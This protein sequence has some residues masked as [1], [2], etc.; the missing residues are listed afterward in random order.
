MNYPPIKD[1][2]FSWKPYQKA[3]EKLENAR[4]SRREL[5]R[6]Q[7]ELNQKLRQENAADVDA[8]IQS[9]LRGEGIPPAPELAHIHRALQEVRRDKQIAERAE[10]AAHAELMNA[11]T[12]NMEEWI[13][14][15]DAAIDK[16]FAAEEKAEARALE[17]M[18]PARERR[19]KLQETRRWIL[20]RPPVFSPPRSVDVLA[21]V[22]GWGDE[23]EA[24]QRRHQE[25]L[26]HEMEE[27]LENER[28]AHASE[29]GA[30]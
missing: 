13:A 30:A 5:E 11:V 27:R 24:Q 26:A 22:Q 6:K 3:L 18:A 25:Q 21:A 2:G 8:A 23:R 29:E 12:M 28:R 9:V 14:E 1:L 19:E 4:K 16:A 17:I 20:H 7:E 10:P 15:V